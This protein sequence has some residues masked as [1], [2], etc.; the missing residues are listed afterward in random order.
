MFERFLDNKIYVQIPSYLDGELT[1]TVLDLFAKANNPR[2]IFVSVFSQDKDHPEL[3]KIFEA[4]GVTE[5]AYNKIHYIDAKG[6]GYARVQANKHLSKKYKYFLQLD[7]HMRF[8]RSWDIR[9]ISDYEKSHKYFGKMVYSVY[10]PGYT[11]DSLD[12]Y[13]T[14]IKIIKHEASDIIP[15]QP[16]SVDYSGG[17]YGEETGFAC[18]GFIFGKTEYILDM[19]YDS[20]I[21]FEGEEQLYSLSLFQNGI[22]IIA[23]SKIY[24]YHDYEGINRKRNWEVNPSWTDLQDISDQRLKDLFDGKLSISKSTVD[25]FMKKFI[26]TISQ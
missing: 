16:K 4:Y 22:K 20:K 24:L 2:N 1:D 10:P 5:Y 19:Q 6:L 9:I 23:P 11:E 7:S 14:G 3:E 18:G 21:Y 15:F 8:A 26:T 12:D 25:A 13:I 17:I